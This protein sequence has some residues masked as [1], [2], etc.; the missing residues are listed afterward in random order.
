[1]PGC[2][3]REDLGTCFSSRTSPI[4][5]EVLTFFL[6]FFFFLLSL[7]VGGA[8]RSSREGKRASRP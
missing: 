5:T 6:F 8:P 2:V 3:V 4:K 1:M 7:S